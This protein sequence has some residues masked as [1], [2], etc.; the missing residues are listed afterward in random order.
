M[1]WGAKPLVHRPLLG[2]VAIVVYL[3]CAKLITHVLTAG[4]YGFYRDE[5]YF[6][7]ASKHLDFGYVD[8]PPLV[9]VVTALARVV[10]GDSA[11]ALQFFPALA[12]AGVVVLAGLMARELGGGRFAQG[13]AAL[14]TLVA[15]N[16][17]VFG[18]WLSM[19]A[20]DQFNWALASYALILVFKRGRPRLWLFFGLAAGVGLLTKVTILYFGFAVFAALLLTPARRHL[21][22]PWPWLG[23]AVAFVFLLPYL[24]WQVTHGWPTLEFWGNYGGKLDPNSPWEFLLEQVLTM[25]PVTLPVWAAGLYY[26]LFS[27]EGRPYRVFGFVF[28]ILFAIFAFQNA[29]FYFLAPAYPMLFAAGGLTIERFIRLHEWNWLKPAYVSLLMVA[30]VFVA[31]L[32]VL[33]VLPVEAVAKTTGLVGG[34]AGIESEARKTAELPQTFAFRH[35][36][37]DMVETI[38]G[39]HDSLSDRERT[40]SCVLAGDFGEAGAVDFFGPAYGLPQAISGH[41]NYYLWGPGGCSGEVV[42]SVGVPLERLEAVFEEIEHADTVTCE[43]C[44]PVE[45]DLPVYVAR[46]P[47]IPFEEAWPQFKHYN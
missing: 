30:G 45:N 47:R 43:Y 4:N 2:G 12:S 32:S 22:T 17:L 11:A 9:A 23:G 28:V 33:P 6:V 5:L 35:G 25:N 15:P 8:F 41:N 20:F 40:V 31:V 3:A 44:M 13:I 38:A 26:Y 21:L 24:Y 19:D 34:N 37:E 1:D 18:T 7:A 27:R 39:V 29:K 14:A 10:F 16:I 46:D 36:W 42:I